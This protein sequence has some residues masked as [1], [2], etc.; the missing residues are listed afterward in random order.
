M[1]V[2]Q[3]DETI[4][5]SALVRASPETVYALV[6]DVARIPQWS[7]ETVRTERISAERFQAWNRRRLGRWRTEARV[8]EQEPGRLFSFVVEAMG[9][10]WTQWSFLIEPGPE[11][12][13]V[14][15]TE[16]CR[17]CVALPLPVRIFEHLFLFVRDRRPDLRANIEA[18]L[19]RIA[20]LAEA[21]E[22]TGAARD[23][24]RTGRDE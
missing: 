13:T 10:D 14:R 12:G 16:Q 19:E 20:A 18:S 3:K 24:Q 8:V 21:Q 23:A 2:L 15:L 11:P 7:P 22:P 9:G 6:S 1:A 17:M 5:A 4:A